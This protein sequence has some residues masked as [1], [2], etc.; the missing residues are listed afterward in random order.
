VARPPSPWVPAWPRR[1]PR[2][3]LSPVPVA[4]HD[5]S[6]WSLLRRPCAN[7]GWAVM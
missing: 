5:A 4:A 7:R 2:I 1:A 3:G 6:A